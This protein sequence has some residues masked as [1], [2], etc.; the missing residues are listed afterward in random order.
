MGLLGAVLL[1]ILLLPF[2]VVVGVVTFCVVLVVGLVSQGG[3]DDEDGG[4]GRWNTLRG[5]H[6]DRHLVTPAI[7]RKG[8][9]R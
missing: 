7:G 1:W 3:R 9:S 2:R 6:P 8:W 5:N 4:R